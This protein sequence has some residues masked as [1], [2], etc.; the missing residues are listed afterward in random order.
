MYHFDVIFSWFIGNDEQ[1]LCNKPPLNLHL[2]FNLLFF[3]GENWFNVLLS[4]VLVLF[5]PSPC[6]QG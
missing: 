5:S 4:I 1:N 6:F 3:L 2:I